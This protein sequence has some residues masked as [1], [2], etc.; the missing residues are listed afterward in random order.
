[1]DVVDDGRVIP[2]GSEASL[3]ET[4]RYKWV[5]CGREATYAVVAPFYRYLHG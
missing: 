5:I 2:V 1:M 3:S 4:D